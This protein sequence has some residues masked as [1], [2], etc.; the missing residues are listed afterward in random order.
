MCHHVYVT[1]SAEEKKEAKKLAGVMIPVYASIVLGVIALVAVSS[2]PRQGE[3]V[4]ST[5]EPA[6]H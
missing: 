3:L 2:A 4:A 6:T 1:L 5:A